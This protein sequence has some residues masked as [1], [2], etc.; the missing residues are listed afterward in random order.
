MR[1]DRNGNGGTIVNI[2]SIYGF[3]VDQY[4]PV[5]QA[6]KFAVFGFTKS[7]GHEYN[8]QKSGVRVIAVCPG[9]VTTKLTSAR[10]EPAPV[11]FNEDAAEDLTKF[12]DSNSWQEVEAVGNAA[13]EIFERAKS[14]A[15]WL[16]EG[17]RSIVEVVHKTKCP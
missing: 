15:A 10:S 7:L 16:I 8:Y 13:V 5:Y 9:F 14:G 17:S 12:L 6:S 4:L 1:K 2:A 3:R 11:I